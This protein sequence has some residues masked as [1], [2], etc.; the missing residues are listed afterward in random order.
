[1]ADAGH[2]DLVRERIERW[3]DWRRK[4][5][6]IVPDLSGAD[7]TE[8]DLSGANFAKSDLSGARLS[9]ANLSGANL[10]RAKLFRADLSLADL[11]RANLFKANLSQADLG[12]ANLN[13][14]DLSSAFLIRANLSGAS[15]LESCLKEANL[16]QASLFR[17]QMAKAIL[18]LTSFFKSDLTGADLSGT[19]LR[20]ANFQ[21]A[22]LEETCLR[23]ANA[24]GANLCF[25][26]LLRTDLEGAVLDNCAVYGTS[27]WEIHSE[28]SSQLDL[29]IMPAQQP[30]LSVDS[31]QTAQL[32]GLLLHHERARDEV[33]AVTLNTVLVIGRFPDERR[34]VLEAVKDALRRGGHSPLV[35]DFHLPGSGDKNEIV[36]TLGRMSRFVVADLT[37][38]RRIAE[39]LDAVV[40]FLPSIPIQP[41]GQAG[42]EPPAESHYPKYRWVLPFWRFRGAAD[43]AARFGRDVVDPAERK[44]AEIRQ[45]LSFGV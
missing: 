20:G 44:A 31:L 23:G 43:L 32:V 22:V 39:T 35:L 17:S 1:M 33:F 40:H 38:D 34:D 7:L 42:A 14:A 12:G 25:A 4:N 21:E 28:G 30:V 37:G 24:A 19:D 6:R 15:L 16:G 10:S 3:N 8:L 9:G 11:S 5:T 41:I 18:R 13:R 29:D 45:K 2:V 26:T 36:K 27:L